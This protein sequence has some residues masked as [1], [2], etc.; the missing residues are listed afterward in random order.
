M[1]TQTGGTIDK[2][3]P[4]GSDSATFEMSEAAAL[5]ILRTGLPTF[6]VQLVPGTHTRL[7]QRQRHSLTGALC[8]MSQ[9]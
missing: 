4:P 5:K 1:C 8:S 6:N 3:I 9:G 2:D 7:V